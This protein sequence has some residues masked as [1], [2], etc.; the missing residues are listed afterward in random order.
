MSN[1]ISKSAK[2][3]LVVIGG[4]LLLFGLVA[5]IVILA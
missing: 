5:I 1:H 2:E 4:T 3:T